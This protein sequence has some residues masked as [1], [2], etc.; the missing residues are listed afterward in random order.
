LVGGD[1][2]GSLRPVLKAMCERLIAAGKPPKVAFIALARRLLTILNAMARDG[3]TWQ[4]AGGWIAFRS[5]L[6]VMRL[7][8]FLAVPC[9]VEG[10][11]LA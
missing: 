7:C 4:Q 9:H 8:E 2:R 3:T 1:A 10:P 5:R 11:Q 6:L